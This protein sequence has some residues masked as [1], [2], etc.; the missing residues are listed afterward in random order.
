MTI[1]G[2]NLSLSPS[3]FI[4]G[5]GNSTNVSLTLKPADVLKSLLAFGTA[6]LGGTNS[7]QGGVNT[8]T[9]TTPYIELPIDPILQLIADN[10]L[11]PSSLNLTYDVVE[12]FDTPN[13]KFAD[14]LGNVAI[15]DCHSIG[16]RLRS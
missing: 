8:T 16:L 9:F 14:T 2:G 7:T 1:S 5:L 10:N 12:G 3:Q 6:L 13:G 11:V 4:N 15:V